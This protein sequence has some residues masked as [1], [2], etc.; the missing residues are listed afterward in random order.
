MPS[1]RRAIHS[2][3]VTVF[4]AGTVLL[5]RRLCLRPGR[6][7]GDQSRSMRQGVR[8]KGRRRRAARVLRPLRQRLC[9]RREEGDREDRPM[10]D[11]FEK[12]GRIEHQFLGL[13]RHRNHARQHSI[14]FENRERRYRQS[15]LSGNTR[16]GGHILSVP[17]VRVLTVHLTND[18]PRGRPAAIGG[19]LL[20]GRHRNARMPIR[21]FRWAVRGPA[22]R[23]IASTR[24]ANAVSGH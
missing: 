5:R 23:F 11:Q 15:Y 16:D 12:P 10:H 9:D 3:A 17:R 18:P 14:Q 2:A 1:A 4:G 20:Q 13:L 21:A 8:A 22:R 19:R 6:R 24:Q 7:L